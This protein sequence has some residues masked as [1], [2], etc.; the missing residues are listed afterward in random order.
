[1][2]NV[3]ISVLDNISDVNVLAQASRF[4]LVSRTPSNDK[5][6]KDIAV[7]KS[8]RCNLLEPSTVSDSTLLI[9]LKLMRETFLVCFIV[10]FELL[11]LTTTVP[12]SDR[13][14]TIVAV[15]IYMCAYK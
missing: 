9:F 11:L 6:F 15:F 2:S 5:F 10:S 7:D 8:T 13:K 14:S 4:I 1:M 12:D 3:R